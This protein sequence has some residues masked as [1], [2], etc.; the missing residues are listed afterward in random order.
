MLLL[1][2]FTWSLVTRF[3]LINMTFLN[4]FRLN[5]VENVEKEGVIEIVE[6]VNL[7]QG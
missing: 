3:V 7:I 6:E 5:T 2:F 1:F 4:V